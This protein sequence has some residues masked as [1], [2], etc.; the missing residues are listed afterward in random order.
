MTEPEG[1]NGETALDLAAVLGAEPGVSVQSLA[2]YIPNK[3]RAGR[4]IGNQRQWVLEALA[5]LGKMGGGATAM[6]PVEGV[7][8][9]EQGQFVWESPV[10]VYTHVKAEEFVA[11][12]PQLREFLHRL[13][14]TSNQGEVAFEFDGRF[15]RI[16]HF[17][18]P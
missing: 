11:N 6:P 15:Y 5:L 10:I 9:D 14:R 2:V 4:E 13:G 8:L 16:R 17:D 12:L 18:S 7:W 3:D 1:T